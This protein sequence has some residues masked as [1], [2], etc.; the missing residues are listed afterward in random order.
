MEYVLS[1]HA[2]DAQR[3][4][5]ITD[6]EVRA[7]MENPQQKVPVKRG[8]TAYQSLI[9]SP[10]GKVFLLRLIVVERARPMIVASLYV[11]DRIKRYWGEP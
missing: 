9:I 1:S 10:S 11:T 7:V 6:A 3:D 8:R 2:K 4:R 5:K